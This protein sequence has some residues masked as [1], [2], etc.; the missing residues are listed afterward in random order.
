MGFHTAL[1]KVASLGI[2]AEASRNEYK[3]WA[4]DSLT[5]WPQRLG[6]VCSMILTGSQ[7][8][9]PGH[10]EEL[11][12]RLSVNTFLSEGSVVMLDMLLVPS[13]ATVNA[14]RCS[15]FGEASLDQRRVLSI[16]S[17]IRSLMITADYVLQACHSTSE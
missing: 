7:H 16:F 11:K 12:N 9:A 6:C 5:I 8:T 4:H 2:K 15:V 17:Q 14:V 3:G 13:K 1:D 10:W